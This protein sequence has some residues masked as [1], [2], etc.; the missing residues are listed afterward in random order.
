M[1]EPY[2]PIDVVFH[3]AWW[4]KNYGL[5]FDRDFFYEPE[6]RVSQE[7][8]MRQLLFERF[9]DLGLGQASAPRRPIIGPILMGSGYIIQEILGCEI[10]YLEDGNPRVVPRKMSQAEA[11]ELQVPENIELAP[12][13][14]PLVALMDALEA[15]FGYLQGDVP[16]HSLI[17]VGIDLRGEDYFIDL[18]ENP[19]LIAHLHTVISRTIYEVARY[20]KARTGSTSISVNR[21]I[22]SFDPSIL[23]LPNCS[24]QMISPEMYEQHFLEYD[25]WMGRQLPPVGFHH[26][27]D[28]A[29]LFAPHYA[30]AGAVYLD[31]GC[32]SDIAACR[33]A[34]PDAWLGLRLDPVKMLHSTANQAAAAVEKVLEE[35]GE[36]WTKVALC[37]INMDYGTP[38]EAIRAMFQTVAHHR[39]NRPSGIE[40]AYQVA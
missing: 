12:A 27:G 28:N 17:N 23:T 34:L 10:T 18:I 24:L 16:L 33:A 19:E 37:S 30:K 2:L 13:M 25:I 26:C 4:N 38:D 15:E 8:R 21:T 14:R 1:T 40:R 39:G 31:V 6:R 11:W 7:Q 35:H 20:V 3:P 36:P 5:V 29:H 32:G 9:G 22:A